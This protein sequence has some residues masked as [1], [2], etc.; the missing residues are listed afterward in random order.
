MVSS[1]EE[2]SK[3]GSLSSERGK[4]GG[5]DGSGDGTKVGPP[6]FPPRSVGSPYKHA[7]RVSAKRLRST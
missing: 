4:D 2:G 7:N 6:P 1:P 5:D 3:G